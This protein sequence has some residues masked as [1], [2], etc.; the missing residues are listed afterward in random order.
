MICAIGSTTGCVSTSAPAEIESILIAQ[1]DAWN[2]GQIDEFMSHYWNS[3]DLAFS[4]A[5]ETTRGWQATLK[6]YQ[7]RY[8]D[9]KAMGFLRFSN[10]EIHPVSPDAAYVLGRWHLDREADDVGGCFTLMFRKLNG[11]WL[12]VHDHTSTNT[13]ETESE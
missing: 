1:A 10:L 3:E 9:R 8:P 13:R 6:R 2:Q 12:I 4:A 5:G 7:Q 11:E